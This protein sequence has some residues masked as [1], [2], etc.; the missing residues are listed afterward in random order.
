VRRASTGGPPPANDRASDE[1]EQHDGGDIAVFLQDVAPDLAVEALTR[2]RAQALTPM[3]EPWPLEA[4]P[5]VPTRYLLCRRDRFFPPKWTRRM[6]R[7]RLGI[8]PD[9]MDCGHTP[10]LSR[11]REL[12]D[13]LEAY[14]S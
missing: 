1:G 8:T 6:V 4:W 11:P 14:A 5:E 13:R 12:A 3:T 2:G 7:D 10:A 9:E